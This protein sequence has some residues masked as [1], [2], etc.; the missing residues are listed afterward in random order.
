[1]VP[2]LD[3]WM[4]PV[5]A[6]ASIAPCSHRHRQTRSFQPTSLLHVESAVVLAD[7]DDQ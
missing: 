1:M 6:W 4:R 2:I 7:A 5:S 3:D